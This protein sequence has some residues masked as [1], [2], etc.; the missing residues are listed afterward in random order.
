MSMQVQTVS[1]GISPN[2]AQC[3]I[4]SLVTNNLCA[5]TWTGTE[6]YCRAE[7]MNVILG[8]VDCTNVETKQK[9]LLS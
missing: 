5:S 9:N 1:A 7:A 4:C 2:H 3:S 8:V 6:E